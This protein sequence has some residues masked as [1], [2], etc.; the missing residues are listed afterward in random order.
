MQ[1]SCSVFKVLARLKIKLVKDSKC[2]INHAVKTNSV[3]TNAVKANAI[4]TN[5]IKTKVVKQPCG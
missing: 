1:L 3:K 5:A 4:K 2:L